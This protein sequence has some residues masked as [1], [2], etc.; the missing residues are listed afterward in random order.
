MISVAAAAAAARPSSASRPTKNV[1]GSARSSRAPRALARLGF[2]GG[3]HEL[4]AELVE[5]LR[6]RAHGRPDQRTRLECAGERA[7]AARDACPRGLLGD[8]EHV[9]DLVVGALLDDAQAQRLA[10]VVAEPAELRGQRGAQLGQL[11]RVL[12]LPQV[13]LVHRRHGRPE[14]AQ[15]ALLDVAAA[16]V[17]ADLAARDREQPGALLGARRPA[18]ATATAERLRERLG[19]DV[20]R[21][22]GVERAAGHEQQHRLGLPFVER[23]ELVSIMHRVKSAANASPVTPTP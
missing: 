18:K 10:L 20:E 21:D 13:V 19:G 11:R 4:A 3:A 2:A 9:R 12:D 1:R 7:Q 6:A 23:S 22:L 17:A 14:L 5:D 8:P 15:S 16:Q